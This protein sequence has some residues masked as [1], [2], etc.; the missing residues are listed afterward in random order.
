MSD[1]D[2][3]I[4]SDEEKHMNRVG[5]IISQKLSKMINEIIPVL[6]RIILYIAI[7]INNWNKSVTVV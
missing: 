5:I 2:K 6:D 3:L 1:G 4:H 7:I